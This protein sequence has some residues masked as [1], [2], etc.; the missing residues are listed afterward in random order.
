MKASDVDVDSFARA[1]IVEVAD[2]DN[3]LTM[4]RI[5]AEGSEK[6][7]VEEA[8]IFLRQQGQKTPLHF[9]SGL[10]AVG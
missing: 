6:Q 5:A 3:V 4:L 1:V 7:T 8:D 2:R 9:S 10:Q